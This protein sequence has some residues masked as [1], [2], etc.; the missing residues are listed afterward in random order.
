MKAL[1]RTVFLAFSIIA[2]TALTGCEGLR[3]KPGVDGTAYSLGHLDVMV[4]ADPKRIVEAAEAVLKEMDIEV[5]SAVASGVD[6]RVVGRTALQKRIEI[7][8]ERQDADTSKYSIMIGS[9][10]DQPLSREIHEK[11]KAKL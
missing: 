5:V 1:G 2:G 9:F 4:D 11:M 3:A 6:G 7:T 8:V 10:G